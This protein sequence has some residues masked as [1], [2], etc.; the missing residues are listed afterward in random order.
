MAIIG[1]YCRSL[2]RKVRTSSDPAAGGSSM[3]FAHHHQTEI[4]HSH[5]AMLAAMGRIT[6]RS[7]ASGRAICLRP[8]AYSSGRRQTTWPPSPRCRLRAG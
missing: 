6:R 4:K 5:I 7:L 3:N 1:C 2:G 8:L